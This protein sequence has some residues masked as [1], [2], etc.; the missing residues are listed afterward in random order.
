MD[1][2]KFRVWDSKN[3]E[4][5]NV[6]SLTWFK[7]NIE[8]IRGYSGKFT[9]AKR[10][11]KDISPKKDDVLMQCTGLKDKNGKLIYEGDILE[12]DDDFFLIK[13]GV[14]SYDVKNAAYT[15]GESNVFICNEDNQFS[16]YEIIGNIHE[17]PELLN[18]MEE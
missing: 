9:S 12:V 8:L 7:D 10:D 13:K 11:S 15:L 1:R 3:K 16:H 4:M 18:K 5:I 17:N 6:S 14:V 2:F